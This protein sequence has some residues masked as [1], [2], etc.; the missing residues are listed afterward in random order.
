MKFL[1]TY[2][3]D[4]CIVR[5]MNRKVCKSALKNRKKLSS[6]DA[7]KLNLP[8]RS[9]LFIKENLSPYFNKIAFQCRRLKRAGKIIKF[10]S[11]EGIVHIVRAVQEKLKKIIQ[12]NDLTFI[13]PEFDF[14]DDNVHDGSS[15]FAT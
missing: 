13:F 10:Y 2:T 5:F 6:V 1:L 4:A 9:K 14:E 11:Q 8:I 15:A 12:M 7:T 3:S